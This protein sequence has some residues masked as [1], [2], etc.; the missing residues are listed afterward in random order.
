MFYIRR[1]SQVAALRRGS[2]NPVEDATGQDILLHGGG[3]RSE[4]AG[5][6]VNVD[7]GQDHLGG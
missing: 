7:R 3:E 1:K 6:R 4:Q 2:R 5:Q